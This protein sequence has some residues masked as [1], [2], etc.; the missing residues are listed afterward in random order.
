VEVV[1]AV[2]YRS[3][4]ANQ[5]AVLT[6]L[7]ISPRRCR[8]EVLWVLVADLGFLQI[9][10]ETGKIHS[11]SDAIDPDAKEPELLSQHLGGDAHPSKLR[12]R[13]MLGFSWG[14]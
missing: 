2:T 10:D 13:V 7:R 8:A 9:S 12:A 4:E 5:A 11:W 3:A 14:S 6:I 1:F